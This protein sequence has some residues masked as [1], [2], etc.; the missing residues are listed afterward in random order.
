[1]LFDTDVLIWAI[2]GN[3]KA[4]GA[5]DRDVEREISVVN[6]IELLQGARNKNEIKMLRSFII[7]LGFSIHPLS[8]EIGYRA[9]VYI[10][11]Y[12]LSTG[13]VLADALVAATAV[14]FQKPLLTGNA[15]HFRSISELQ[16]KAF[17]P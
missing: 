10:E 13:L 17:R 2:R 9:S 6:Y 3:T 15:K 1:M 5:I 14:E 11:E 16:L 12:G 4:A 7:D 8:A